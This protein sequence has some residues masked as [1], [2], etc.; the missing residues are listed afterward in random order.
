MVLQN[1]GSWW[2]GFASQLA[3]RPEKDEQPIKR[4]RLE[5]RSDLYALADVLQWLEDEI[6]SLLPRD[7]WWQY[8]TALA[9]GFTNAVRHAHHDLPEST[10][11]EIEVN[12]YADYLEILIW[13]YGSPFDLE[14]KL[15][16]R[17]EKSEVNEM[18]REGGRGL[19]FM[20]QLTDELCYKRT[21]DNRNCLV[22][23]KKI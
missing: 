23:R 16:S 8:Q 17:Y 13:D 18:D 14:A 6:Y 11:I 4:S 20:H 10:P 22:M 12:V 2:K 7:R 3:K 1:L 5:V 15:K 21:A 9:E 19:I